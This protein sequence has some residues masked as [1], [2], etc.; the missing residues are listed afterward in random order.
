MPSLASASTWDHH[1]S[2]RWPVFAAWRP[3]RGRAALNV[4]T[5]AGTIVLNRIWPPGSERRPTSDDRIPAMLTRCILAG[6]L[7]LGSSGVVFAQPGLQSADLL[8][9]RSVT[10]VR[11]SPDATR[12]AYVVDNNDGAGRPY[13]QLWVMTIA[14]GKTVR[15][16]G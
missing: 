10:S 11:V 14:D 2:V 5:I 6:T 13:G 15:F 9:L 3:A 16:G 8:K 1:R 4:M 12:V 7:A